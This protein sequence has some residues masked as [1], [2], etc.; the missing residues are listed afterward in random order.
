[1][2]L[3]ERLFKTESYSDLVYELGK[4][5]RIISPDPFRKKY[6]TFQMY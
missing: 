6:C 3:H 2:F 1:M 5:G 4:K